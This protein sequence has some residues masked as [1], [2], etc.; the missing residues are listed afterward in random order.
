MRVRGQTRYDPTRCR[1]SRRV[2]PLLGLPNVLPLFCCF[3]PFV[4]LL[5]L[6]L[7]VA[8]RRLAV[9]VLPRRDLLGPGSIRADEIVA[10]EWLVKVEAP[11]KGQRGAH[12]RNEGCRH[13]GCC[14]RRGGDLCV[15][16][17]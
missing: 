4:P 15:L 3:L 14:I 10:P 5:H 6:V 1:G 12:L 2:H 11:T 17:R 8:L 9:G 7:E 16:L 13:G